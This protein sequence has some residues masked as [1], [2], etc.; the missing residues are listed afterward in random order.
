VQTEGYNFSERKAED[1]YVSAVGHFGVLPKNESTELLMKQAAAQLNSVS[2]AQAAMA[3][4]MLRLAQMLPEWSVVSAFYGV[5][6]VLGPQLMAEI[7]DVY[8]FKKK[9]SLVNG[10]VEIFSRTGFKRKNTTRH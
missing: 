4:E 6:G 9:G 3:G 2:I 8:R 1:V 10:R 5:G 7:G